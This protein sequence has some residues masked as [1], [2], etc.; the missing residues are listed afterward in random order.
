MKVI[1]QLE[2]IVL[3][4]GFDGLRYLGLFGEGEGYLGEFGVV[5]AYSEGFVQLR[6]FVGIFTHF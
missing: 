1:E 5:D 3:G 6:R 2:Q 4:E